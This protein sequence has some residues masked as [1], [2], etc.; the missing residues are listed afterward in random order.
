MVYG[1]GKPSTKRIKEPWEPPDR[2]LHRRPRQGASPQRRD[3]RQKVHLVDPQVR[4]RRPHLPRGDGDAQQP[5]LV[6]QAIPAALHRHRPRHP[7]VLPQLVRPPVLRAPSRGQVAQ[8]CKGGPPS[9]QD[10]FT[11]F[12]YRSL[13]REFC[14]FASK[15]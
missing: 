4:R 12:L 1:H 3:R 11:C 2:G 8:N 13:M 9:A 10:R 5:E 6:A 14:G 7:A 15:I